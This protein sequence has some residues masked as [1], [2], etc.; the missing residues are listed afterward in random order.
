MW[1]PRLLAQARVLGLNLSAR[2]GFV[3][4]RIDGVTDVEQLVHVT[5]LP[6]D[7]VRVILDRLAHEGAIEPPDAS[8]TAPGERGGLSAVSGESASAP[9]A[10]THRQL[11]ETRLHPR[12]EDE[13]QRLA[14]VA[15]EPELSALCFDPVPAVIHRV[16][17]NPRIG[18]VH[19]RLIAAHHR[20]PV[21]LQALA[22]RSAFLSDHE[23]QRLLLRN[24]QSS[25]TLV[26][27]LL[28]PRTLP[29]IYESCRSHELAERHRR[30]ARSTLRGRFTAASSDERAHLILATDGRALGMLPGVAL[31]CRTVAL[32]CARGPLSMLL[33]ENLACWPATPPAL[34]AHLLKQPVVRQAPTLGLLL[35]RHPNCP[36]SVP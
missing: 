12:T 16:L 31:D 24:N 32:L 20:N 23:V 19:A 5:G 36:R 1:V 34:V 17:E 3:L 14:S 30:T 25:D 33:V 4:S 6:P 18:L 26:Q 10:A 11:F 29:Q 27:R 9:P 21:G 28:G 35:R 2:E 15:E 13:R 22:A 8:S 7:E